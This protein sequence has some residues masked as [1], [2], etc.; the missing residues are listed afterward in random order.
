MWCRGRD[1]TR[2]DDGLVDDAAD[3][4]HG[5]RDVEQRG[6]VPLTPLTDVSPPCTARLSSLLTTIAAAHEAL[7]RDSVCAQPYG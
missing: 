7:S 5:G 2:L 4:G 1:A 3:A 6:R